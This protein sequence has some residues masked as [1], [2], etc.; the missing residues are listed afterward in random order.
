MR[1]FPLRALLL[2]VLSGAVHAGQIEGPVSGKT[3]PG[4]QT[5]AIGSALGAPAPVQLSVPSLTASGAPTLANVLAPAPGLAQPAAVNPAASQPAAAS[6]TVLRPASTLPLK[7]RPAAPAAALPSLPGSAVAPV[8]PRVIGGHVLTAASKTDDA[9]EAGGDAGRILFDQGAARDAGAAGPV[10]RPA[11]F[12]RRG[13]GVT[14]DP[15]L[16]PGE[17]Y[18]PEIMRVARDHG[19]VFE[20]DAA[21]WKRMKPG[22]RYNYVIFESPD[23]TIGMTVGRVVPGN[24]KEMGVKHAALGGGRPVLFAG[25]VLVDPA[26]G[27]PRLDFNS[28]TY[29]RVGLDAR[30]RPTIKNARALAVHAAA[31]LGTSVDVFDHLRRRPIRV[32]GTADGFFERTPGAARGRQVADKRSPLRQMQLSLEARGEGALF[33]RAE[34]V[35]YTDGL[36]GLPNRAFIME[37]AE[38]LLAGVPEPTVAM[39]DMNNFG[40]VNAGLADVHGPLTGKQMGDRMLASAG[41]RIDAIAKATGVRAARLGG[42]EI[43]AFGSMNDIIE[44]ARRMREEFPPEK[45]LSGTGAPERQAIDAAMTRMQ[46]TGPVGDFTY[47]IAAEKGRG[48]EGALKAADGVLN[49]AKAEGLRGE[50]VVEVPGTLTFTRLRELSALAQGV[51]PRDAA[52]AAPRPER[53]AEIRAL[54][55]KLTEKEYAVFLEAVFKDPLTL[56]RTAEWIDM[57]RPQWEADYD[58]KGAAAM[59]SARNF[60]A[61][62]DVLGHDAGDRYLK[63]LGVIMRVEVNRLRK[64]GYSVEEPVRAGGKEFL[65]VGR[66][67]AEV[68]RLVEEKFARKLALGEVL[69]SDQLERLRVEAP[70]RGLIPAAR[71]NRLGTLRVI[72]EPFTGGF[73]DTLDRL[74]LKLESVKAGE[75][76]AS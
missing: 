11:G 8:K 28:G 70:G 43:V 49:K 32:R 1:S 38:E 44:F 75:E 52:P 13:P 37:K 26:S 31:I 29:S 59:I 39:L 35:F 74:I 10:A 58:G 12:E 20:A 21:S 61:V 22:I 40:A 19:L 76:Q 62:N 6:P 3:A 15:G 30:W 51:A 71:V 67:A 66:D 48:F 34:E 2:F 7:A 68:A 56:T 41:P 18:T 60:K 72:D 46:R 64:L 17:V 42:E 27:R 33:K 23:G 16:L 25:E 50:A 63:R 57:A 24:A 4:A 14:L 55:E 45:V 65:L 69:P 36:M 5:G 47:G 9:P 54:K 53:T 73:N